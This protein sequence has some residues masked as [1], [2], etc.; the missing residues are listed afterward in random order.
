MWLS[1]TALTGKPIQ[2]RNRVADGRAD[3]PE[4]RLR[5]SIAYAIAGQLAYVLTQMGV[6]SALA[7]FRGAEAVGEFGLA[8]ALATPA[9]MFVNM[10]GKTSLA[11][12]VARRYSF[13][14]YASVAI[15]AAALG[16]LASVAAGLLFAATGGVFLLLLIVA[17]TK[18]VESVST[19]AYGAFQQAGRVDKV[20][21]SLTLRGLF[22]LALFV[23]LLAFGTPVPIAFLAQ[24]LVWSIFA[25][26]RDYP[27]ASRMSEGRMVWPSTD[28]RRIIQLARETAPLGAS[29]VVNSLLVS[30]PRLFVERSLGLTAVGL[31]TVVNYFQ[32]AGAMLFG[33]MSQAI[34][35]RF[36]RLRQRNS[37]NGLRK[38]IKALLIFATILSAAGLLVAIVAGEW[39]LNL[40]FGSQFAAAHGLLVLVAVALCAK[41]YG[42]IPQ[43][44]LHAERRYKAF[45][46]REIAAIAVCAIFLAICVPRWGLM[47]AGYAIVAAAIARLLTIWTAASLRRPTDGF[48]LTAAAA[49]VETGS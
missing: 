33:A 12:D 47:G 34:V 35:N 23:L 39:V 30:L 17:L 48:E 32:Q 2:R 3:Y 40:I 22:T 41:L 19:L 5:H 49:E 6:L 45:L 4:L 37:K 43:S 21:I 13:A 25:F 36:A 1:L 20:A 46:I 38:T 16:I 18:A 9:F 14:E 26:A 11:S 29:H 31:L 28:R 10:G 7:H 27:L 44:L 8:L 42:M 24:L 15:A